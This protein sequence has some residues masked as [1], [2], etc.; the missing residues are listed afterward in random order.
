L[1]AQ[2]IG[3]LTFAVLAIVMREQQGGPLPEQ[4]M[5]SFTCLAVAGVVGLSA[6]IVRSAVA[7]NWRKKV[8][9][10]LDPLS[11][12][13]LPS[14]QAAPEQAVRWWQ[15]YQTRLIITAAQLEGVIFF[16]LIAYL[17][18]GTPWVLGVAALFFVG[19]LLLFPTQDR[20]ERWVRTQQELVEEQKRTLL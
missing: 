17:V 4:P 18:E 14:M 15:F 16:A 12:A 7:A 11:P 20:V 6:I 5:L 1:A 19:Q 8:A 2:L 9:Q 13:P 3:A 10:G